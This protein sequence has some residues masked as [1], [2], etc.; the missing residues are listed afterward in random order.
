VYDSTLP[1]DT[2]SHAK[3]RTSRQTLRVLALATASCFATGRASAQ[4]GYTLPTGT[5]T[6]FLQ[7]VVTKMQEI[8][9]FVSSPL[10]AMVVLAAFII[11]AASWVFAPKSGAVGLGLRAVAAGIVVFN[12]T[13]LISYLTLGSSN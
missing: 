7:Q 9:S 5:E 10:G 6:G 12:I 3:R 13:A 4:A 2:R 1:L 11:A 8:A